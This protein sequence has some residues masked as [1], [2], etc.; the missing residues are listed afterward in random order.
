[1]DEFQQQLEQEK[2]EALVESN[3]QAIFDHLDEITNKADVYQRRWV[4]E[5]LQN[6]KDSTTGSQKVS[7]EIVLQDSK[8]IFRHNGNPF[9][10]KEIT[11]LVYHGSTKKGQ[12]DKTGKFGT[13]FIA[14][15]LL[16][17][18]VRVSGDSELVTSNFNSFWI[19]PV[20]TRKKLKSEWRHLGKSS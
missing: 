15:H 10:N 20:P 19:A 13:G 14:T 11:H 9:S 12:T 18:R 1:M 4:W 6:S 2:D 7:V 5:L 3:A 8:L 16:S 17:K